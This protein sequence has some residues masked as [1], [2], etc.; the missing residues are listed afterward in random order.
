M[1]TMMYYFWYIPGNV[2]L[3]V[4]VASDS[5]RLTNLRGP[6]IC[7]LNS[8]TLTNLQPSKILVNSKHAVT[9]INQWIRHFIYNGCLCCCCWCQA[10]AQGP[11]QSHIQDQVNFRS[12]LALFLAEN[13]K[14]TIFLEQSYHPWDYAW[15]PLRQ[16]PA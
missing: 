14:F 10:Q 2:F 16:K 12:T 15:M 1:N 13:C 8:E 5:G 11:G 7:I 6:C 4:D 3:D 9:K